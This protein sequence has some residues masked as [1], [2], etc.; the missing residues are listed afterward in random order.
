M[1]QKLKAFIA[2]TVKA[3]EKSVQKLNKVSKGT[4]GR[5]N[6]FYESRGGFFWMK[7]V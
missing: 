6:A 5:G 4:L 3:Q 2:S 1:Y 7:G